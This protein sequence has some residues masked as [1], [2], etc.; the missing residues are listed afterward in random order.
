MTQV[1]MFR[2]KNDDHDSSE[3]GLAVVRNLDELFWTI[4]QFGDPYQYEFCKAVPGDALLAPTNF[5]EEIYEEGDEPTLIAEHVGIAID[6]E[7]MSE[8]V[9]AF[10]DRK[11]RRFK[12]SV[13]E[14]GYVTLKA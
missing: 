9:V 8:S 7:Y 12:Y 10:Q 11:W 14:H 13:L 2:L 4:D 1:Y 3:I 6:G 5:V